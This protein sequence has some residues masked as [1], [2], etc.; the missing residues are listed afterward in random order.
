VRKSRDE[1]EPVD[2]FTIGSALQ[3][4][5]L[6][7]PAVWEHIRRFMEEQGPHLP[8]G[9]G[10]LPAVSSP[11]LRQCMRALSPSAV[12]LRRWWENQRVAFIVAVVLSPLVVPFAI[13]LSFLTWLSYRT[14]TPVIWPA[15]VI[16]AVGPP[17]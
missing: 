13:S 6:T 15:H 10:T 7:V 9:E 14:S 16:G 5:E 17:R 2:I 4:G 8:P 11:T 3:M 12:N 1:P